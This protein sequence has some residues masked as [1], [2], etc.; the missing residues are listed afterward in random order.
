MKE[1]V[2]FAFVPPP[3]DCTSVMFHHFS[4]WK[5]GAWCRHMSNK[6]EKNNKK[7]CISFLVVFQDGLLPY[8]CLCPYLIDYTREMFHQYI[9]FPSFTSPMVDGGRWGERDR[10]ILE[11]VKSFWQELL[12]KVSHKICWQIFLTK[13]AVKSLSQDLL[14]KVSHKICW[15]KFLTRVAVKSFS[16]D[17]LTNIS[18]KS[19]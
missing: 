4:T 6:K 8:L 12:L 13:F 9:N 5:E 15:Q 7:F 11:I 18:D 10:R 16:Q 3:Q 17:L 2:A 14:S 1:A 19:C